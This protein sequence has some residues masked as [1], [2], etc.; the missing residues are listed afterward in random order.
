MHRV[1][2][3]LVFVAAPFALAADL[4]PAD[5]AGTPGRFVESQITAEELADHLGIHHF[6]FDFENMKVAWRLVKDGGGEVQELS[7]GPTTGRGGEHQ[8]PV[9]GRIQLF[10]QPGNIRT[11]VENGGNGGNQS[12]GVGKDS[13]WYSWPGH[14]L[15]KKVHQATD[16]LPLGKEITL[17]AIEAEERGANGEVLPGTPRKASVYLKAT[18]SRP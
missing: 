2:P 14:S 16:P 5:K 15:T 12:L 8:Q 4:L 11:V 18:F 17:V 13:L 3:L 7:G 9:P 1:I 6:A 10:V